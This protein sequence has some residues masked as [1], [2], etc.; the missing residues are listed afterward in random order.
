MKIHL[1]KGTI[2][3]ELITYFS[4]ILIK[5]IIANIEIKRIGKKIDAIIGIFPLLPNELNIKLM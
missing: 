2:L 4:L 3:K 5:P 1:N